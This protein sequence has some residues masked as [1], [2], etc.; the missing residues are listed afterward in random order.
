MRPSVRWRHS[1]ARRSTSSGSRGQGLVEFAL[2]FPIF[3]M[4]LFALIEFAFMF[5]A[6]L[7]VNQATRNA[8]LIAAEAGNDSLADCTILQRIEK[9]ISA[10]EATTQIQSVTIFQADRA[11]KPVFGVADSY[12]HGGTL[13]CAYSSGTVNLPYTPTALTY[14]YT[15]RCN[16][17]KGCLISGSNPAAYASLDT[18]GVKIVYRYP[19]HT[20]LRNLLPFLP[21]AGVGYIDFTWSNV[22]RMEPVL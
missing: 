6:T 10:P 11:G 22:M 13:V 2:V 5:A 3:I 15:S 12:T 16:T 21:G 9:D 19:W 8:S 17:I 1:M 7:S 20:Q 14:P 4:L 18:I